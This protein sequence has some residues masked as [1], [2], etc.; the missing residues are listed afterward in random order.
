MKLRTARYTF[1]GLAST[2][3]LLSGALHELGHALAASMAG[4]EVTSIQPWMIMGRVHVHM[5]GSTSDAWRAIINVSGMLVAVSVGLA[6][7]G[8]VGLSSRRNCAAKA[9]LWFFLAMLCQCLAWIIFPLAPTFG[10]H[11]PSDDVARF[12]LNSRWSP[13]VVTAMGVSIAGV[14]AGVLVW[15]SKQSPLKSS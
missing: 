7:T 15:A 3:W 13:I 11:T 6:G 8:I 9:G 5:E 2:G 14:C 12:I 10:V 1:V 4:L